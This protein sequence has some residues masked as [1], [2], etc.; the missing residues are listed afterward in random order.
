MTRERD[1]LMALLGAGPGMMPIHEGSLPSI[2][3]SAAGPANEARR[4]AGPRPGR[5]GL[6]AVHAV[7][8]KRRV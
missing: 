8:R 2:S 3:V 4:G 7:A 1:D 5:A 6:D